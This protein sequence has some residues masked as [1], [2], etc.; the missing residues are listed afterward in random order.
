[1][2][3]PV[4]KAAVLQTNSQGTI[5]LLNPVCT[6]FYKLQNIELIHHQKMLMIVLNTKQKK[7]LLLIN[8]KKWIKII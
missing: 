3:S 5:S 8:G 1:M 2:T 4:V 7:K 6:V